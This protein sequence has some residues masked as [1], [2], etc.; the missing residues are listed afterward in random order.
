MSLP[1]LKG[2]SGADSYVDVSAAPNLAFSS[3]DR[4]TVVFA[5]AASLSGISLIQRSN[6]ASQ[7]RIRQD[8]N[9]ILIAGLGSVSG[10]AGGFQTGVPYVFEL[11]RTNSSD[12]EVFLDGNSL[13]SGTNTF[14]FF[15][16]D[17]I[18]ATD[19]SEAILYDY[20]IELGGTDVY[21]W[22]VADSGGAGST[23]IAAA[24]GVNGTLVDFATDG[25]QWVAGTGDTTAPVLSNGSATA[26]GTTT[27]DLSF[28]TDEGEGT[29]YVV[30][31]E[32]GTPPTVAQIK[33]GQDSAGSAAAFSVSAAVTSTGA[34]L[35]SA[36]GLTPATSYNAFALQEDA[37]DPVNDSDVLALGSIT[38]D[39][40]PVTLTVPQPVKNN[41]GTVLANEAEITVDIYNPVNGELVARLNDQSTDA[42]GILSVSSSLL[43]AGTEYRVVATLVNGDES[44]IRASTP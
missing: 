18:F 27:A 10:P 23:L 44:T 13:G 11:V 5:L 7:I 15:W 36:S 16:F 14:S 21:R 40:V 28:D 41:T 9:Q 39:A 12:M 38:T 33:A 34:Q 20:Q 2:Q 26:T 30:V 37:A 43:A 1:G 25:T 32:S 4:I 24:G 8:T 19:S 6:G 17:H 3:F 31:T 29:A 42:A 22:N 35:F